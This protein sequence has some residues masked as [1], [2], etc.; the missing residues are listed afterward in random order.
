[1][2]WALAG[3]RRRLC[4]CRDWQQQHDTASTSETWPDNCSSGAGP[5]V[6]KSGLNARDSALRNLQF[7]ILRLM[8]SNY[9]NQ[10]AQSMPLVSTLFF[11]L[12]ISAALHLISEIVLTRYLVSLKIE[13]A[14]NKNRTFKCPSAI[15]LLNYSTH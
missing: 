5:R 1:M 14:E 3:V 11:F 8:Y 9:P 15:H 13:F 12:L 4:R 2:G 10:A 6:P 7:C